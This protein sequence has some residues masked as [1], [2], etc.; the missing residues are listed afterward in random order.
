MCKNGE[1]LNMSVQVIITCEGS[2]VNIRRETMTSGN[3]DEGWIEEILR[4]RHEGDSGKSLATS[5]KSILQSPLIQ[6][7]LSTSL[8][9]V[10][11]CQSSQRILWGL[12]R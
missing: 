1:K 5:G 8:N 2:D 7:H 6:S 4:S 9:V 10:V 11:R 12:G 3:R